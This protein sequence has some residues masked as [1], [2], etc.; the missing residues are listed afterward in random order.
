MAFIVGELAAPVKIDSKPFEEG[1]KTTKKQGEDW[2]SQMGTTFTK[3]GQGLDKIGTGLTTKVTLPIVGAGTAIVMTAANFEASMNRVR[4]L[5]GATGGDLEALKQQA[6]DLGATTQY[7]A[8]QAAD[9][10]GFLAMAGFK[11]N[12]IIGAMPGVLELAAS[13]QMDLA[14]AADITSNI[15]TGYGKSVEELGHVNDVLVKAM[16]SANVDLRMLGE[17]MKYAGPVAAGVGMQFEEV[18]A[19]I[20][21]MGN[22]GIQG[23]MAGTALRGAISALVNPTKQAYEKM[24]KMG[25]VVT[26]SSGKLK[27]LTGIVQE[28]E[29]SGADAADIMELFGQRAGPAMIALVDQGSDALAEFTRNLEQSEGAAK[30]IASVNMEGTKGALLELKSAGEAVAISIAESGLLKNVTDTARGFAD[31]LRKLSETNPEMLKTATNIALVVAAAGPLLSVT[32]KVSKGIGGTLTLAGKLNTGLLTLKATTPGATTVLGALGTKAATLGATAGPI[33]LATVMLGGMAVAVA[34]NVSEYRELTKEARALDS[35]MD[36]VADAFKNS[37][38][39]FEETSL[40]TAAAADLAQG[41]IDRLEEL[42]RSGLDNN[43]AQREYAGIVK[44]LNELI[45]DLNAVID[46]QTGKVMGGTQALRDNTEAWKQNAVAQAMQ[47]QLTQQVEAHTEALLDLTK[48]EIE[49]D[50]KAE[51]LREKQQRRDQLWRQALKE[52]GL[53]Q[54]E[55]D[56][57]SQQGSGDKRGVEAGKLLATTS[58]YK[59]W[60]ELASEVPKLEGGLKKLDKSVAKAQTVLD[61]LASELDQT[62]VATQKVLDTMAKTSAIKDFTKAIG[63]TDQAANTLIQ[64]LGNVDYTVESLAEKFNITEEQA[65]ALLDALR[66]NSSAEDFAKALGIS[67]DAAQTLIDVLTEAAGG[68]RAAGENVGDSF[69]EGVESKIADIEA[70]AQ[71]AARSA[72]RGFTTTLEIASPSKKGRRWGRDTV[73]GVALGMEDNLDLLQDASVAMGKVI[74]FPGMDA[75]SGSSHGAGSIT[76]TVPINIHVYGQVT[77]DTVNEIG[78]VA[79]KEV[80]R[81]LYD[82]GTVIQR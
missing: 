12:D 8:S 40:K 25:L 69:V 7:S 68:A 32:G 39:E 79:S 43:E 9:A 78:S 5:T 50:R 13:A 48:A 28:L 20:G 56:A 81:V 55:W 57:L 53:S 17:S 30:A 2:A 34:R 21:M 70:I 18:A 42:E 14:D 38:Q 80:G 49:R 36:K 59:E 41:Y 22:A 33:A 77:R 3:A 44:R 67:A 4:G 37:K 58:V 19:A 1:L 6:K 54:K 76:N 27:S 65:K 62:E 26:D 64:T 60:H 72:E 63:L 74:N 29:N 16:T 73:E 45:P 46:D 10:M 15:L 66:E 75:T 11:A 31:W 52:M 82:R 23:S 71:K 51:E 47:K 35:A 24:A 61:G